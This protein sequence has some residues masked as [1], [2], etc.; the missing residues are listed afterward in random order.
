[1]SKRKKFYPAP[2]AKQLV[3]MFYAMQAAEDADAPDGAWQAM[4]EDAAGHFGRANSLSVD[5][6]NAFMDFLEWRA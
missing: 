2:N 6:H 5:T 4:L 3:Q 1:M